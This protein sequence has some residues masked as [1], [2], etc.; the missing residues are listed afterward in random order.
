MNGLPQTYTSAL[1]LP[2]N[3]DSLQRSLVLQSPDRD[4]GGEGLWLAL[5]G[6]SLL[7][8]ETPHG[9]ALP[10][11][12]PL[13]GVAEAP[14]YLGLWHDR[15][16]RLLEVPSH[17][18]LS[19]GLTCIS[20]T[21][22]NPQLSIDLLSLAG[23]GRMI[24]HWEHDSR[25]CAACGLVLTRLPG[26][27]GKGCAHC[28]IHHFPHIHPCAIVLVRRGAEV[29]L[30]R[31]ANWPA[32]RYSLVA[33]FLEFGECLEEAA[34]REVAEE[35]GI[36][37]QSVGYLGS[38]CWPFPSQLMCGFVAEYA[39]GTLQIDRHELD[40]ARWF[41]VDQLPLLPPKRSIARYLLDT[42]LGLQP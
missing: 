33:G 11:Q 27:W 21:A 23:L 31:K 39:G 30:T 3:R 28:R 26:E 36:R 40:D 13:P 18:T 16:C 10:E 22:D 19:P 41:P 29:L 6:N 35:T 34:A 32:R 38:Q 8:A 25:H 4:P 15:P 12:N 2:F 20:F 24:L 17:L 37:I 14:L 7:V 9:L 1:H 5:H 42:Q